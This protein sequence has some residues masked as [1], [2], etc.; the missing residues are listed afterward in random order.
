MKDFYDL[1]ISPDTGGALSY[2]ADRATLLDKCAGKTYQMEGRIPIL[3]G[4]DEGAYQAK[5]DLHKNY[6]SEFRYRDHYQKDAEFFDYFEA[7][8]SPAARHENRRLHEAILQRL[9]ADCRLVLDAGCGSAWLAKLVLPKGIGVIST[10]I[11]RINPGKALKK[12]P[13]KKHYGLVADVF[14]LPIRDEALDCIVAAEIM[15]HLSD[16]KTFVNR[17]YQKIRPGGKLIITT[18]YN[19]QIQYHLCVHCNRPTPA[20]AHLHSFHERN[21]ENLIPE[22]SRWE[23]DKFSNKYLAKLRTHIVLKHF[24]FQFWKWTDRIANRLADKPTRLLIE[25]ERP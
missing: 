13:D 12:Y 19:E 8:E 15:E 22:N 24:P 1:L 7:F 16:P 23:W 3:I 6:Q 25:I 18:P 9:P 21:I 2:D 14:N 5:A 10:D 20:H 4:G 11:S 17:L